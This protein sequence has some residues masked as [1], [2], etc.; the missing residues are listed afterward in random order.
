MSAALALMAGQHATG[1]LMGI[2]GA[3]DARAAAE[4]AS[5]QIQM[6]KD[7]IAA[8]T[9]M[10]IGQIHRQAEKV[11]ASQEASF[12]SGGVTLSGSAMSVIS[13]TINDAAMAT[14]IRQRESDY[15]L[16]GLSMQQSEYD[17]AASDKALWMNIGTSVLGGAAGMAS[18][19]AQHSRANTQNRGATG[20]FDGSKGYSTADDGKTSAYTG[21]KTALS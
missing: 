19:Y 7:E 13:D 6:Q 2:K 20:L 16:M 8:R 17:S 3:F 18:S 10:Q 9:K 21:N 11:V 15:E 1:T 14:Y 5:M 12:I 4:I